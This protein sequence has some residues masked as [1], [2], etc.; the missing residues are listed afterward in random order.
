MPF[1]PLL[2]PNP[3][4]AMPQV[5]AMD[6]EARPHIDARGVIAGMGALGEA[7]QQ[8]LVN[9]GPFVEAAGA[10]GEA[11]GG[12]LMKTGSLLG[13][14]A[15]KR[16][17]ALGDRTLQEAYA[18]MEIMDEKL[19]AYR[20]SNPDSSTW[21]AETE[22]LLGAVNKK[23]A[24]I[25]GLSGDH[26]AKLNLMVGTYA[27]KKRVRVQADIARDE[28][29][30]TKQA[31]LRNVGSATKRGDYPAAH[32]WV[33][34]AVQGGYVGEKEGLM[35]QE[36]IHTEERDAK[37]REFMN[38][39]P[40]RFM[41][42]VEKGRHGGT[43][44]ALDFMQG[45]SDGEAQQA[46]TQAGHVLAARQN[47][48]LERINSAVW[49]GML[50]TP[51][52]FEKHRAMYDP[53]GDLEP[54]QVAGLMRKL[55]G[56][57]ITE[58][59]AGSAYLS[60]RSMDPAR[61]KGGTYR[62]RKEAQIR[63]MFSDDQQVELLEEIDRQYKRG[64]TLQHRAVADATRAIQSRFQ[65]GGYGPLNQTWSDEPGRPPSA[66]ARMRADVEWIEKVAKEEK[67]SDGRALMQRLAARSAGDIIG[68][69]VGSVAPWASAPGTLPT[70]E[71][72]KRALDANSGPQAQKP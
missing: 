56:V 58:E 62:L 44:A 41:E 51:E 3:N 71:D 28:F 64:D 26:Q 36:A 18:D 69:K 31:Y 42:E 63:A 19:A 25:K 14:L 22:R 32:E 15:V 11:I 50:R 57:P 9:A 33:G 70:Q 45:W 37:R 38:E 27:E 47:E 21:M 12:A 29:G 4:V 6:R 8:P 35:A 40:R 16:Q 23:Y 67:V 17:D 34:Q 30:R 7:S 60:I 66:S 52:D 10:M 65:A 54:G 13:A 39:E 61:D 53:E 68:G 55:S 46:M 72:F 49:T 1:I 43:G 20:E 24:G 5:P 59:L 48:R 2:R